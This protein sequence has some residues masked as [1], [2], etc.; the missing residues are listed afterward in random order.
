[1]ESRQT[2]MGLYNSQY[3]CLKTGFTNLMKNLDMNEQDY[4]SQGD[5]FPPVTAII[6]NPSHILASSGSGDNIN[7]LTSDCCLTLSI[8]KDLK[9]IGDK[10]SQT[11]C[12][13]QE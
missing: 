5:Q 7:Q 4:N 10:S 6:T 3:N 2:D 13:S 9:S 8:V 11:M 12:F 1:M